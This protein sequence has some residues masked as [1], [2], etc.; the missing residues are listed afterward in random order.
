MQVTV[1]EQ[2]IRIGG[3][4]QTFHRKGTEF[5]TGFHYVGGL[6]EGQSLH[7]LFRYFGLLDLPWHRLDESCFDEVVIGNRSFAFAQ[8]HQRFAETL[9]EAFPHEKD[10]INRYTRFLKDVGDHIYDSLQPRSSEEFYSTSLFSKSAYDYLSATIA[11]PLLRKVL[12]GTSLKMEL[13]QPTLPLYIFA[14]IN[15]SFIQSAWRLQGGGM[16]IAEHLRDDIVR[17]GGMVLTGQQVKE[18]EVF[19]GHVSGVRTQ[20]DFYPADWVISNAHPATTMSLLSE[21]TVRPVY[22][23]RI[24]RLENTFGMFTA[25]IRLKGNILPYLNRNVFVHREDADLWNPQT[26]RVESVLVSTS[27]P[28]GRGEYMQSID[29]LTPMSWQQVEKWQDTKQGHRG[30]DYVQ[31][32]QAKTEECIRLVEN[33]FP[34]LREAIQDVYTSTPLS[35]QYYTATAEGSAYGIRK[36][37]NNAMTT[38]LTSRTPVAGLLLTGQNLNLHGILGVS[39]TSVFTTAEILGRDKINE[40]IN[41]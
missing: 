34:M 19:A 12:S 35:Y 8:G 6:E 13:R 38:V 30:E 27:A 26:D 4:L 18:I 16:R 23:K 20:D 2:D 9:A 25:N 5:D 3:C 39:M 21:G 17:M 10:N 15:N 37:Y 36:D 41:R 1:L 29:L 7:R 22:R 31:M 14:Q 40:I 28:T 11:D 32:K 24:E 33:R